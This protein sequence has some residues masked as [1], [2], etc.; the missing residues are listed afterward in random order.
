M[1]IDNETEG[2]EKFDFV[3]TDDE[4]GA[5]QAAEHLLSLGHRRFGM[6]TFESLSTMCRRRVNFEKILSEVSGTQCISEMIHYPTESYGYEGALALLSRAERPEAVFA[7]SDK[8][9]CGIYQ[10]AAELGFTIPD[11]LSVIGFADLEYAKLITPSLTTIRQEPFRIGQ[12]AVKL[13]TDHIEGNVASSAP[14]RIL[15]KPELIVR[16]STQAAN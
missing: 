8:L 11:D 12:E 4:D 10:A 16:A 13:I 7:G 15:L 3:G 14:R 2:S 6:V 9:A 1:V 5:R